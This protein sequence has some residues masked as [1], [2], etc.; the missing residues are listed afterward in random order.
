MSRNRPPRG[1]G[2]L[3][4]LALPEA[5]SGNLPALLA[6]Q[7]EFPIAVDLRSNLNAAPQQSRVTGGKGAL[8]PMLSKDA[9]PP[10]SST[11]PGAQS[12]VA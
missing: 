2:T 4:K 9:S 6:V 3:F 10:N 12:H 7:Q 8:R 1:R 5:L 11:P